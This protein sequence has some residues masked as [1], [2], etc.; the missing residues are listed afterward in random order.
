MSMTSMAPVST[1]FGASQAG[2]ASVFSFAFLAMGVAG[3]GW[4]ALADRYGTRIVVLTG[5]LLLGVGLLASSRA[6][7]LLEFQ[8][9]F[10]G[11][12]GA[13]T[14]SGFAPLTA[15]TSSW[16]TRNRSLAVAL[17]SV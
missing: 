14:G 13:A 3:F 10:G 4:G 7:S 16:F 2:I 15:L 5:G 6:T 1:T 17:V 12:V 8:I 11:V 9:L